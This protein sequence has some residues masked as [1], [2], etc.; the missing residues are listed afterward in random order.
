MVISSLR[1]AGLKAWTCLETSRSSAAWDISSLP[2][3]PIRPPLVP[4]AWERGAPQPLSAVLMAQRIFMSPPSTPC[5]CRT[6]RLSWT[7]LWFLNLHAWFL[8]SLP[9]GQLVRW[10]PTESGVRGE[11]P[12]LASK[13]GNVL[14]SLVFAHLAP[15]LHFV[16]IDSCRVRLP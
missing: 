12:T 16:I 11:S 10:V 2:P 1:P 3:F 6:R 8:S 5:P 9:P 7:H 13:W 14:P 15:A 4:V